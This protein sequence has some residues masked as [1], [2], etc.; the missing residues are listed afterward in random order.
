MWEIPPKTWRKWDDWALSGNYPWLALDGI[1]FPHPSPRRPWC[2]LSFGSNLRDLHKNVNACSLLCTVLTMEC[3]EIW[4]LQCELRILCTS[5]HHTWLCVTISV[6]NIT[7][8]WPHWE[9][10]DTPWRELSVF[11]QVALILLCGVPLCAKCHFH[12]TAIADFSL[13]SDDVNQGILLKWYHLMLL[14]AL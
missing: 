4:A 1:H 14:S 8:F 10:T 11:S 9:W 2:T 12:F 3:C 13:S 6:P 5:S 7:H